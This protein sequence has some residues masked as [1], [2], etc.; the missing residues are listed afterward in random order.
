MEMYRLYLPLRLIVPPLAIP[1]PNL[2]H[3]SHRQMND[4]DPL[5]LLTDRRDTETTPLKH[6]FSGHYVVEI[7]AKFKQK[8]GPDLTSQMKESVRI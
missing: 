1:Y 5:E 7:A 6:N 2:R 3:S 8:V 4:K